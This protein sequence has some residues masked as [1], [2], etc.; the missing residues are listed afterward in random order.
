MENIKT[1]SVLTT[2]ALMAFSAGY[3]DAGTYTAAN[4]LFSAHVTGNF[5]TFAFK[6]STG[7]T[8]AD[9]LNLISFP[10]FLLA[11]Y[12]TGQI[13]KDLQNERKL[14][15]FIGVLLIFA[16]ALAYL[17]VDKDIKSGFIYQVMLMTIVFAMGIQNA[18]NK[19]YVK[20]TFGPTTVMTGNVTKAVLDLCDYFGQ[21]DK[22][23]KLKSLNN[24][25]VLMT[26][27]L[28]G[29]IAGA[30]LSHAWGLS[31]MFIPGIL[32]FIYYSVV[33]KN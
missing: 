25:I 28:I 8:A 4:K 7:P 33:F 19:I 14:S 29:C 16:A 18:I 10:V 12:L 30:V 27:F 32:L 1:N 11:V 22:I 13:N 17:L 2:T 5:V 3:A 20:S 15:M 24:S 9:F 23:E 31:S 6:L 26:G 21:D